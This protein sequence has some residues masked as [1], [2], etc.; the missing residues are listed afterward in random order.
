MWNMQKVHFCFSQLNN[1]DNMNIYW[2]SLVRPEYFISIVKRTSWKPLWFNIILLY[3]RMRY[4]TLAK[5]RI[6][7]IWAALF[8]ISPKTAQLAVAVQKCIKWMSYKK[9]SF[10]DVDATKLH[11]CSFL[12]LI[13]HRALSAF[14]V[15]PF[16][17]HW[18]RWKQDY[19]D[20][21]R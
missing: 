3:Y 1:Y 4:Q 21:E 5:L 13:D 9:G 17:W 16:G 12:H 11:F 10:L 20:N 19:K 7:I 18:D 14:I 15:Q 6:K 2:H 8:Q